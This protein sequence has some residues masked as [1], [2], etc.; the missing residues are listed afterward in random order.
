MRQNTLLST[1]SVVRPK[2]LGDDEAS[3]PSQ[4]GGVNSIQRLTVDVRS[5]VGTASHGII[6]REISEGGDRFR[7]RALASEG[8]CRDGHGREIWWRR[9]GAR[10]RAVIGDERGG[11][12]D[13]TRGGWRR[14]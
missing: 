5:E 7:E 6:S 14:G 13:A 8:G 3:K 4:G 10:L 9:R 2:I 11:A 12:M 1:G